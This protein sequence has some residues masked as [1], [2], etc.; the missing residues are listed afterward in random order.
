MDILVKSHILKKDK[1]LGR[2]FERWTFQLKISKSIGW[3]IRVLT[4]QKTL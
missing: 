4:T 2:R 1:F 3:V